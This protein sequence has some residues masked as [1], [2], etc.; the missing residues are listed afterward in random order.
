MTD[1]HPEIDVHHSD[2]A[3]FYPHQ[4][5]RE[6]TR[7]RTTEAFIKTYGIVHPGEQY[8]SD[9]DQRL[10]PMHDSETKLGARFFEAVGW[11][12]PQW[13]ESNADLLEGYGDAVMPRDARVGRALVEP[14]RQRRAP[15]HA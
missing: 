8:E 10:S 9:R 3:R 13:Y 2:I 6:H 5:R 7:L 12:R 4:M 14:D 15:A 11:E 1:G